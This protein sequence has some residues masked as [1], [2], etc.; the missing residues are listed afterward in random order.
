MHMVSV[1]FAVAATNCTAEE[2]KANL[3]AC[4]LLPED[5]SVSMPAHPS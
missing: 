1:E 4:Q 2:A 5:Q 3:E